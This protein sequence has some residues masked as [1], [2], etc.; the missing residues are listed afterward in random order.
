MRVV[1]A[2]AAIWTAGCASTGTAPPV[3]TAADVFSYVSSP[4]EP[5]S[6]KTAETSAFTT[7]NISSTGRKRRERRCLPAVP[8]GCL[9]FTWKA[10]GGMSAWVIGNIRGIEKMNCEAASAFSSP[11]LADV[12]FTYT[13]KS[14]NNEI[15]TR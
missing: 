13:M 2:L 9:R 5:K 8:S 12:T 11:S 6:E 4:L 3:R 14:A 15:P 7:W 10:P 1:A